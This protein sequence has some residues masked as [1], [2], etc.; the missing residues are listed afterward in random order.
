MPAVAPHVAHAE[1]S[2]PVTTRHFMNYREG[3]IYGIAATPQR[4]LTKKLGARTPVQGLYL[5]GQDV[6]GLGVTGAL[7]GGVACASVALG[8]NLFG[9]VRN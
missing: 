1:L 4:F 9:K 6:A 7:F 2:T 5:T 3:E 8:K